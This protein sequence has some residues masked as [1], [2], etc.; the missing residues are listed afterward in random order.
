M[1]YSGIE[2]YDIE[3]IIPAAGL[4]SRMTIFKPTL[5][6]NSNSV[7]QNTILS[8]KQAGIKNITVVTGFRSSELIR[9]LR[10]Y[11]V[12]IRKNY[13]YKTSDMFSSVKLGIEQTKDKRDA[14]LIL[15]ADIPLIRPST[16]SQLVQAFKDSK[17]PVL[18]PRFNDR[19]GHPLIISASLRDSLMYWEGDYGLRGWLSRIKGRVD[20]IS[21]PDRAINL[22]L[23]TPSQYRYALEI[24]PNRHI[25]DTQECKI[26]LNNVLSL[27]RDIIKHSETV[28]FLACYLSSIVLNKSKK[29]S[30][31]GYKICIDLQLLAASCLLH[32]ICKGLSDHGGKAAVYLKSLGFHE[33]AEVV[34]THMNYQASPGLLNEKALLYWADKM[35][36]GT[37]FIDPSIRFS[38]KLKKYPHARENILYRYQQVK[39]IESM[40]EEISGLSVKQVINKN[41]ENYATTL[42]T[43]TWQDLFISYPA[44]IY[45]PNRYSPKQGGNRVGHTMVRDSGANEHQYSHYQS[46]AAMSA[47]SRYRLP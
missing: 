14:F 8:L 46:V 13:S 32:D 26:L 5:P 38:R 42:S 40:F 45:W 10:P 16:I 6:L 11:Q 22:D 36:Q 35:V 47:D 23:D 9:H 29:N 20:Y 18:V 41:I 3:A 44:T 25:P 19:G 12:T 24:L 30:I 15:P 31:S 17:K 27:D 7:I 21:V 39:R 37:S 1:S 33:V 4:S 34:T 43:E 2:N 28:A